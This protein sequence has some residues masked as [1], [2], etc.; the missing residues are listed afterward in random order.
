M[1][2]SGVNE[3]TGTVVGCEGGAEKVDVMKME[4]G[5]AGDVINMRLE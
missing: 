5:G 1:T 2:F 4:V 3:D